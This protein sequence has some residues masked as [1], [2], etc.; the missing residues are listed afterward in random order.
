M[1][2]MVHNRTKCLVA[3]TLALAILVMGCAVAFAE[4]YYLVD[5]EGYLEGHRVVEGIVTF[6]GG[7]NVGVIVG[8]GNA[9]SSGYVKFVLGRYP[10]EVSYDIPCDGRAHTVFA[11]YSYSNEWENRAYPYYLVN[12]NDDTIAYTLAIIEDR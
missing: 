2:K 3:L 4:Y 7:N 8:A 12:M 6:Q 10:Y 5:R 1:K 9:T 11:P